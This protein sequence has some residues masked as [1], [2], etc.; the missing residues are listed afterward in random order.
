MFAEFKALLRLEFQQE[1]KNLNGLFAHLL[2]LVAS[3]FII[4]LGVKKIH[5]PT[6]WIALFWILQLFVALNAATKSFN[7]SKGRDLYLYTLTSP[8][9]QILSKI[10]FNSLYMIGMTIIGLALFRFLIGDANI[11]FIP[12]SLIAIAGT[13]ALASLLTMMAAI[14]FKVENNYTLLAILSLPLMI[15]ILV[16]LINGS[17]LCLDVSSWEQIL[18]QVLI[19]IVLNIANITLSYILFPYLCRE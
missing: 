10:T 9:A 13:G 3:I 19:L 17:K 1:L 5:D 2:Y 7:Y 6:M 12:F 18:F 15:P 11:P 16:L 8:R 4:Y 14:S